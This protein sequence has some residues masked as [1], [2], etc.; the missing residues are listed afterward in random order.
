MQRGIAPPQGF[1]LSNLRSIKNVSIPAFASTS[2]AQ[3]PAGPPPTTATRSAKAFSPNV[4]KKDTHA[5]Y[6]GRFDGLKQI[7]TELNN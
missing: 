4:S 2:A 5:S 3:A 6:H 7:A 1:T